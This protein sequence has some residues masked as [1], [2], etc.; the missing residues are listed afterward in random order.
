VRPWNVILTTRAGGGRAG[1]LLGAVRRLGE[2]HR[3]PFRNVL[4]GLVDDP[5]AFLDTLLAACEA[6]AGWAEGL[7]RTIPLERVF[8]FAPEDL[9]EQ[10]S[11]SL[12]D[13]LDRMPG[14]ASCFVRLERRGLL[15]QLDSQAVERAVADRLFDLAEMRAIRLGVSFSDPDYIVL[16]E[17]VG[18]ECGLALITRDVRARYPFVQVK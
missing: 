12:P 18:D 10:W 11:E 6:K 9:V 5:D 7:M 1:A 2:F 8:S 3:A 16:A 13:F 14:R 4:I 17:T 15:G